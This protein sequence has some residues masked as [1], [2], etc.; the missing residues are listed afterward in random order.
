MNRPMPIVHSNVD[1][2]PSHPHARTLPAGGSH[3]AIRA[4]LA[5][6][7]LLLLASAASAASL[8]IR[9]SDPD[10]AITIPIATNA[11][12]TPVNDVSW[13][14]YGRLAG[15]GFAVDRPEQIRAF[16]GAGNPVR[17]TVETKTAF[18]EFGEIIALTVAFELDPR[19][20]VGGPPR[21]EWGEDVHADP[22]AVAALSFPPQAASRIRVFAPD[23]G[24]AAPDAAQ[25]FATIDIIADSH[26][27]RYYLW[28]L[29]PMAVIF[30][31]LIA[32]KRWTH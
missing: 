28:Y 9:V 8:E 1:G 21:F 17:L 25:Q 32:R 26:A 12:F 4:P 10:D 11:S 16:D 14:V 27:D 22:H 7:I 13:L 30:A 24:E 15:S 19:T 23:A 29:L 3:G 31:L 20:L 6:C 5:A 18:R 2:N